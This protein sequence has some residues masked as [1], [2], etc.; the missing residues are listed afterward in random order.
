[1][2][3]LVLMMMEMVLRAVKNLLAKGRRRKEK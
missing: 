1:M 2:L 3:V